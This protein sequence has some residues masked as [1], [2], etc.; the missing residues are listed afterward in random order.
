MSDEATVTVS[1]TVD[2]PA[3]RIY[4]LVSDITRM[5]EWSPENAGGRWLGDAPGPAVGARFKGRNQKGWRRWST[6]CEVIEADPGEAFAFR[7]TSVGG[8]RVATWRYRLAE[9]GSTTTVSE[10]WIDDRAGVMKRLGRLV[11][12]VADRASYN[13]SGME[14]T[15]ANLKAAAEASK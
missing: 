10:D 6:T 4:D 3:E 7:V 9:D 2:A 15:L 5:G 8:L 12:G 13:R 14:E 1:T 11:S